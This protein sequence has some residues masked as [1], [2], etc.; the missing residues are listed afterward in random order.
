MLAAL[1]LLAPAASGAQTQ[2][3]VSA[4]VDSIVEAAVDDGGWAGAAVAVVRGCDTLV[5]RAYG[6]A[7]AELDV[8]M[9]ADAIFQI[10]SITKQ[11]TGAALAQ[12]AEQGQ[13]SLDDPITRFLPDYPTRGHR[14]TVRQLLNH[15]SGIREHTDLPEFWA[16]APRSLPRDSLVAMFAARPLDS[17]PGS[18]MRYDNSGYFLAGLVIECA[19]GMPYAEYLRRHLFEP[20]GMR[21]THYCSNV[22]L[23]K[24][25]AKGYRRTLDG[26]E[27]PPHLDFA[28]PYAGGALCSTVRDLVAW[29]RALHT[30]GLLPTA[31]YR[32]LVAPGML[33]DGSRLRYALGLR[34]D[35]L[36]GRRALSHS[37][38]IPG[39]G[40][41]MDHFPDDSLTIVVLANTEG[42]PNAQRVAR[43]IR[44]AIYGAWSPR[45]A[46]LP[47]PAAEY[48]GVYR[49][50]G[51]RPEW[52]VR[53][54]VDPST[55]TLTE[56]GMGDRKDDLPTPLVH[57]GGETFARPGDSPIRYV[58]R[59]RGGRIEGVQVDLVRESVWFARRP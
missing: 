25:R 49:G 46:P 28:W 20:A 9:P 33:D 30:G 44:T 57:L 38:G 26:L 16:L 32:T 41:H 56:Q 36:S 8:P 51:H 11:F 55:G 48:A 40:A 42:G 35:S 15:T 37:G 21:D 18:A 27:R 34:T 23:V 6:V 45:A 4:A 17:A 10:G 47:R 43:A 5:L 52:F 58:V 22:A 53:L 13:L 3:R 39:F 50:G 24:K 1:A 19:S 7:D 2:A 12:L 54:A 14:I 31:A 59:R 29:N